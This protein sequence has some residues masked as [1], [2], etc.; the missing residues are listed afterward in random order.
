MLVNEDD[1]ELSAIQNFECWGEVG[2]TYGI[3]STKNR[4]LASNMIAVVL[5]R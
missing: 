5:L 2:T 1:G 3:G 4:F